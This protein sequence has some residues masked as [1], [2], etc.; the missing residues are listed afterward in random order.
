[1]DM[2]FEAQYASLNDEELLHVAANR[3]DLCE[4]A[5][6]ALDLEMTRRGLTSQ[7]ALEK[8]TDEL[9]LEIEESEKYRKKRTIV[10]QVHDWIHT[11][12]KRL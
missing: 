5:A 11:S 4:E 1:M 6:R 8:R 10:E 7:Q 3:E 9:R 12:E 2:D